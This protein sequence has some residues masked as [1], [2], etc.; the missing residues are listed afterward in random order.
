MKIF[1]QQT[2]KTYLNLL[3]SHEDTE[4]A[5]KETFI[6]Y[7][8]E[9]SDC[10]I[11]LLFQKNKQYEIIETTH[12]NVEYKRILLENFNQPYRTFSLTSKTY[13]LLEIFRTCT[14]I[15][16]MFQDTNIGFFL[17]E[18]YNKK[19]SVEM[20]DALKNLFVFAIRGHLLQLQ[21]HHPLFLQ[22][23]DPFLDKDDLF[24]ELDYL[25]NQERIS[26]ALLKIQYAPSNLT[27]EQN[28][29]MKVK[30]ELKSL[31]ELNVF[32]LSNSQ[33]ILVSKDDLSTTREYL[34]V[35]LEHLL[36]IDFYIK[37]KILFA[38]MDDPLETLYKLE[39]QISGILDNNVD[40]ADMVILNS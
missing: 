3:L 2:Y 20:D 27:Y 1:K 18:F 11:T 24:H 37:A 4:Q 36:N 14:L 17:F 5:L 33:Y 21:F 6:R 13:P 35:L 29:R 40:I 12:K 10:E 30:A 25:Q 32:Q 9:F 7:A 8:M 16:L 23:T 26:L 19:V 39:S 22:D 38:H 28:I 15:P 31:K 34:E